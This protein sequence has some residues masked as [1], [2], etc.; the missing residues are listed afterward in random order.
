MRQDVTKK[1]R[2]S[3]LFRESATRS[4]SYRLFGSVTVIVPPS[5]MVALTVAVLSVLLLGFV[6][7]YVEIPQRARAVGV[8]MPPNGLLDIVASAPGRVAN[9]GVSEGQVIK[10]GDLLLNITSDQEQLAILQLQSFQ[11]EI[12]LLGEAYARQVAIDQQPL[13][14]A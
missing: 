8:L 9:I 5:G 11:A 14:G 4:A 2:V 3:T 7:W 1:V 10:A 12:A 6:A 13:A